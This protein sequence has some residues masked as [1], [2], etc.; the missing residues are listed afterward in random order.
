LRREGA[1]AAKHAVDVLKEKGYEGILATARYEEVLANPDVDAVCITT[2][3]HWHAAMALA[4]MKAGKDV[5]IEKPMTLTIN[6]GKALVEAEKKFGRIVQ[7]GSQQRSSSHFRIAANLVRNGMIGEIK[8]IYCQLG[9]FPQPPEKET[10]CSGAGG[11]ST[12]TAGSVP[13]RF[14]SIPRTG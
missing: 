13:H 14:S 5:Y 3:D 4:A 2:P 9:D 10:I 8:E 12:T 11:L 6:E 1:G 7:V